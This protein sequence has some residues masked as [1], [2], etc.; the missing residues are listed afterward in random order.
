M[1]LTPL[2]ITDF[3]EETEE[4]LGECVEKWELVH[5]DGDLNSCSH[6]GKQCESFLRRLKLE[7]IYDLANPLMHI[8]SQEVKPSY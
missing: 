5:T 8:N 3:T 4:T 1:E 7:L 2:R 6:F